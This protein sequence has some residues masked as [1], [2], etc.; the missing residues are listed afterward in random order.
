MSDYPSIPKLSLSNEQADLL[1]NR[2]VAIQI[3]LS[4][5]L[6]NSDGANGASLANTI[7]LLQQTIELLRGSAETG[8]G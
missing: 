5:L 1:L 6:K 4:Q 3:D 8:Q 2:L 7:S